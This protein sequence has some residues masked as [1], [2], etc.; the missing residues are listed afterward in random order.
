MEV[1]I[2]AVPAGANFPA[3]STYDTALVTLAHQSY[4]PADLRGSIT[5]P[6]DDESI[7]G[8][9]ILVSGTA[10]G[11]FE[12]TFTVN[13]IDADGNIINSEIVT[14]MNPY[15][16]DEVPFS[17][18]LATNGYTGPAEIRAF[19]ESAADGSEILIGSVEVTISS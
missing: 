6:A 13:L 7:S 12:N 11:I 16:I 4:R 3:T 14:V 18:E 1:S 19:T 2:I 9:A 17:L 10:S 15:F 8:S 5:T